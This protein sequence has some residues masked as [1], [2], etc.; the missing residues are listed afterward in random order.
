MHLHVVASNAI[1]F[2]WTLLASKYQISMTDWENVMRVWLILVPWADI[3]DNSWYIY[4]YIHTVC[5]AQTMGMDNPWIGLLKAWNRACAD[6][7]W[8]L[9]QSVDRAKWK[10][11]QSMNSD[12]PV[13]L[14]Y[15]RLFQQAGVAGIKLSN[16]LSLQNQA[17]LSQKEKLG[18]YCLKMEAYLSWC[19]LSL[20]HD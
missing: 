14:T 6:N 20:H 19:R 2:M 7:P 4:M 17:A 13:I 12:N 9:A 1:S 10:A 15:D 18:K 3:A 8:M 11:L 5:Y 16:C